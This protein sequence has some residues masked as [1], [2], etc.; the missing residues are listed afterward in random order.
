MKGADCGSA[1][2][3][4]LSPCGLAVDWSSEMSA[5]PDDAMPAILRS[6]AFRQAFGNSPLECSSTGAAFVGEYAALLGQGNSDARISTC[7]N[8]AEAA[9]KEVAEDLDSSSVQ[10][11]RELLVEGEELGK[12]D[13]AF[14]LCPMQKVC[15]PLFCFPIAF[16]LLSDFLQVIL[17]FLNTFFH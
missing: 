2:A 12:E 8:A 1:L 9:V 3:A 10:R 14:L 4:L 17:S 7:R 16:G 6:L 11:V 5:R 15:E 13:F